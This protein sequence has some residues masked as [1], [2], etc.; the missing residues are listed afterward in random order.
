MEGG[1]LG[2]RRFGGRGLEERG[3]EEGGLDEG[4]LKKG[5]WRKV[6][7]EG[8]G[9]GVYAMN[10][11]KRVTACNGTGNIQNPLI[12]FPMRGKI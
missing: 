7:V 10:K 9:G 5:A 11:G 1:Y 2:G 12:T 3:L 8:G 6:E 4:G